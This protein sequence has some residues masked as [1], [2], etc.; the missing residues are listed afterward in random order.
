[1]VLAA[2]KRYG[3]ILA[4]NGSNWF[5]SGAPDDRWNNDQLATL[6]R[7]KGSDLEVVQMGPVH[8]SDPTGA[9]PAITIFTAN[10]ATIVNGASTVLTW[11][12][13]NATRWFITPE[14]GWV[15]GTSATVR[16]TATTTYTLTAEGPYGSATRSVTVVVTP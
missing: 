7:I 3:M 2:L 4:D 13:A 6:S 9:A 14:L 15:T 12:S 1:V 11:T 5:I 8:T 16:P 10:P